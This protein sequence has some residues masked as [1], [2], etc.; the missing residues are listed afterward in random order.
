MGNLLILRVFG[1]DIMSNV[2][3][4]DALEYMRS[5]PDKFFIEH[6]FFDCKKLNFINR[7]E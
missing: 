1:M 6:S 4:G 3:K 2:I 7:R 5:L